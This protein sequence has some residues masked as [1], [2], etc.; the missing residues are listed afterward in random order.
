MDIIDDFARKTLSRRG[1]LAGAG[2]AA[3]AV[4]AGCNTA[5][6]ASPAPNPVAPTAG[7]PPTFSDTDILNFAL[8]LEYLEAEFYLRAATGSGI[9]AADAG[10]GAG[11]VV[12]GSKVAGALTTAQTQLINIIAQDEYNHVKFLRAALGS[13]AVPRPNLDLVNSFNSLAV[14][15]GGGLTP[16]LTSFNPFASFNNFLIGGFIFEDVGVTAYHGAAGLLTK[17]GG[18]ITPA[19]QILAV[20]AYHASTLRT[21]I[22]G[23]SLDGTGTAVLPNT[24][25]L[26][27][28]TPQST[29]GTSNATLAT[30]GSYNATGGGTP[31]YVQI[32]NAIATFRAAVSEAATTTAGSE[33]LLS[34]G[35]AFHAAVAASGTT[36]AVPASVSVGSVVT[37]GMGTAATY[38]YTPAGSTIIPADSN[39]IAFARTFD[40][41]LHIVYGSAVGP[42]GANYGFGLSQGAFF[43]NGMNGNIKTTYS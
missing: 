39:S 8:N 38:A 4:A 32:A 7:T 42:N 33:T 1:F 11:T 5:L 3:A 36:P 18:Y 28:T 29:Y 9:P 20:E 31:T 22:V 37:T 21:L 16:P 10:T 12:G 41:V 14:A 26:N 25:P 17:T 27:T 23:T 34:N 30:Y 15:A 6:P 40:Q 43:P 35:E 19:A 13:A 2:T 24:T